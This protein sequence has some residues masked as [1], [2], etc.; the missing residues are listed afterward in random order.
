M[1]TRAALGLVEDGVSLGG[2]RVRVGV[3]FGQKKKVFCRDLFLGSGS[4]SAA[5]DPWQPGCKSCTVALWG[6]GTSGVVAHSGACLSCSPRD[7]NP[8]GGYEKGCLG[9]HPVGTRLSF[10]STNL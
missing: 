4:V 6:M 3:E 7:D 1:P 8:A 10:D 5:R 2:V 9:R